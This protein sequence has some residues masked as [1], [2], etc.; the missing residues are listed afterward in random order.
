V[1]DPTNPFLFTN[2]AFSR[3]KL[4]SWDQCIND[5][6]KAIDLLPSNM[7]AY[8]HLAQA[9][10]ALHHPNEALNSALTA[11]DL[12]LT[13]NNSSTRNVSELVLKAKKEKWEVRERERLRTRNEMLRELE[14]K[15]EASK[16]EDMA[17]MNARIKLG[18][19]SDT[20]AEEEKQATED[21][22]RRKSEEL[23]SIFALAD[24]ENVQKRVSSY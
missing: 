18:S 17:E 21:S 12:C 20:D 13:S 11:Y 6:L 5:C 4:L 22:T 15:L 10:L 9:Q 14:E 1:K 23:R 8:Y 3:I 2:R 7:K 24:P 16:A 19:L